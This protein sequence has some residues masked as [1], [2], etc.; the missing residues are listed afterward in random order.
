MTS[1][2]RSGPELDR[3]ALL[4]EERRFLLRSLRD[5]EREHEAGDVDEV[6]YQTLK[7]GYTV[8]AATV[9][10]EIE[11]GRNRLAPK[12][13]RRWGRTIVIGLVM[14]LVAVGIGAA[15]ASAFG[16]R[17]PGRENTGLD[18]RRPVSELLVEAR[19]ALNR[20]EFSRANEL[21]GNI[22]EREAAAGRDH[23]EARTYLGWTLALDTRAQGEAVDPG[24]AAE[25]YEISLLLMVQAIGMEPTYA[26][27]YCFAA[28]IQHNFVGDS[29]AALPFVDSCEENDP[30]AEMQA[31]IGEFADEIRDAAG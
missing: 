14:V 3:L 1:T 16:E 17:D 31:L 29:A 15:L 25:R 2:I 19:A 10:R 5:L 13:P 6:D 30:P 18:V 27:P 8:R 24:T 20:G 26:D 21:F 9:L 23:P 28:I 4:E 12:A 7:D 11:D 22:S